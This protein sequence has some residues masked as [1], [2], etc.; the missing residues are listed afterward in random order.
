VYTRPDV[1]G[2]GLCRSVLKLLIEHARAWPGIERVQLSVSERAPAARA[3]YESLGLESWGR[4][5]D[6]L[7]IDGQSAAEIHMSLA[8]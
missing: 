3:L 6:A 8:L 5:P 4:E 1:R 7:R 2:R